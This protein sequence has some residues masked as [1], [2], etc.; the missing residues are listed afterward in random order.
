MPRVT[1][2][3]DETEQIP[4]LDRVYTEGDASTPIVGCDIKVVKLLLGQLAGLKQVQEFVHLQLTVLDHQL[5]DQALLG[6]I[7]STTTNRGCIP[8]PFL[9]CAHSRLNVVVLSAR[10]LPI[11]LM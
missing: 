7:G 8:G 11:I 10:A 9:L 3:N 2:A 6:V 5:Q 4:A 1:M